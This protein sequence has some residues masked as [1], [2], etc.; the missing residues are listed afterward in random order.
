MLKYY[1]TNNFAPAHCISIE[2]HNQRNLIKSCF[3]F[4]MKKAAL[5]AYFVNIEYCEQRVLNYIS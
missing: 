4:I 1:V 3:P 5:T 2:S